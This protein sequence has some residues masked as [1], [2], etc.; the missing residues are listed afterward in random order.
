MLSVVA[1]LVLGAPLATPRAANFDWME[2]PQPPATT[3]WLIGT[4]RTIVANNASMLRA[5]LG[6]DA[7]R[8]SVPVCWC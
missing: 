2:P 7:V 3:P 8:T 6:G 4:V 5:A 1:T